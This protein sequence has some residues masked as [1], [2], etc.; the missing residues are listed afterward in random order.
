[1]P[2]LA[3]ALSLA[4]VDRPTQEKGG[5]MASNVTFQDCGR[6]VLCHYTGRFELKPLLEL[7]RDVRAYCAEH[8][9]DRALVDL[10]DSQGAL[11]T[12]DRYEH[13]VAMA[14]ERT[15]PGL[16]VALVVRPDQAYADR[17]W[18]T[19]TRN[20]GLATHVLTDPSEALQWLDAEGI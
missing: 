18:E 11:G 8:G 12:L 3:K 5:V 17:F 20:R 6:H 1:M 13:A 16:R 7:A 2:E 10:R 9:R 19:L 14:R 15:T 4:F